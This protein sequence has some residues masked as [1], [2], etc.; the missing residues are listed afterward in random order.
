MVNFFPFYVVEETPDVIDFFP[1]WLVDNSLFFLVLVLSQKVHERFKFT[2]TLVVACLLFHAESWYYFVGILS[3]EASQSIR[4]NFEYIV[5][6]IHTVFL[7]LILTPSLR[8]N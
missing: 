7:W 3:V 5:M 2:K 8:P 6:C 1:I 4:D